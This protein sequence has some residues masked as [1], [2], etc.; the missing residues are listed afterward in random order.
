MKNHSG[1]RD[2]SFSGLVHSLKVF[3]LKLSAMGELVHIPLE[4]L[5]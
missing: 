4:L 2:G 5:M 3:L 1:K